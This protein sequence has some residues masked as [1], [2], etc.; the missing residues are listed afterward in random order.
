[1][2]WF[3]LMVVAILNGSVRVNLII[4]VT[5]EGMG[6]VISTFMLCAWILITAWFCIGWLAPRTRGEAWII[7]V[8]WVC[9]TLAF[10]F[11]AGHFL[12]GKPWSELLA[13]YDVLEGR[14]WVLV[15]II[16]LLAPWIMAR[17]RGLM[18]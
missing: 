13:D 1:M 7:G 9:M 12:F 14:V 3:A 4:P 10:E 17:A 5:G 11:L 8:L 18:G 16:T 15:P 6:H 2:I